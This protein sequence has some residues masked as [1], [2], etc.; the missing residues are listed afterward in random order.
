MS[1]RTQP[2]RQVPQFVANGQP[3]GHGGH[4]SVTHTHGLAMSLRTQFERRI[5]QIVLSPTLLA[6]LVF[7]YGFIFITGYLSLTESRLMPNFDFAGLAQYELLFDN[8][9]WW[10]SAK[11]LGIFGGLFIACSVAFG[12]FVAIFL[13]Q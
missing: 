12:L 4:P 11:N 7:V 3:S 8:D 9:R 1:L 5:P 13:D 10:T 2:E 6:S